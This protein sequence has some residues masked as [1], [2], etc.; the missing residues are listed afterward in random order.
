[1]E[2]SLLKIQWPGQRV[3]ASRFV[4]PVAKFPSCPQKATHIPV[5][6]KQAHLS[7]PIAGSGLIGS[8]FFSFAR[9]VRNSA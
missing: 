2:V 9:T 7:L 8:N 1:M 5:A 4:A 6:W 3:R